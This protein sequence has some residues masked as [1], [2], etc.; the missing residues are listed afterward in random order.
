MRDEQRREELVRPD[1][2]LASPEPAE[3]MNVGGALRG[4]ARLRL[5]RERR[6]AGIDERHEVRTRARARQR[7]ALRSCSSASNSL[8]EER[9]RRGQLRAGREAHD[10]DLV[11]IDVPLPRAR[12]DHL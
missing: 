10:A 12:A 3:V 5:A 2:V 6:R 8:E 1:R 7:V 11:R 9:R 4:T